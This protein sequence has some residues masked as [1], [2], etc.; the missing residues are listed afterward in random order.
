M[1]VFYLWLR[2]PMSN[3][4]TQSSLFFWF[5]LCKI[6][7]LTRML[8][9]WCHPLPIIIWPPM[10]SRLP[11]IT[12]SLWSLV[13]L[14]PLYCSHLS[15]LIHCRCP[16]SSLAFCTIHCTLLDSFY[17]QILSSVV[18]FQGIFTCLASLCF[19]LE[20]EGSINASCISV[21]SHHIQHKLIF[22]IY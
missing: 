9:S 5:N 18:I 3:D 20:F 19:Y 1:F 16:A 15:T 14:R 13:C 21:I 11:T 6:N 7:E 4:K 10:C 2:T 8:L 12:T 22:L 17:I